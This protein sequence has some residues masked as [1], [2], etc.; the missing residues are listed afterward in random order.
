MFFAGENGLGRH[1]YGSGD[2]SV[3]TYAVDHLV[4]WSIGSEH[5]ELLFLY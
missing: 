2:D 5:G 4:T 1:S 3:R